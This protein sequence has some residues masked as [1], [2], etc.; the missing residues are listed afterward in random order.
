MWLG[1]CG[2]ETPKPESAVE[3]NSSE[4]SCAWPKLALHLMCEAE[5]VEVDSTD[6]RDGIVGR[7]KF[8]YRIILCLHIFCF[9]ALWKFTVFQYMDNQIHA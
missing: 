1:M 9:F 5:G 8:K 4:A 6:R 3:S 7:R 2:L